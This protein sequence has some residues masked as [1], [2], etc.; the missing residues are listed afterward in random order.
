MEKVEHGWAPKPRKERRSVFPLVGPGWAAL[1]LNCVER[2]GALE[3][4]AFSGMF[5]SLKS[6]N[7]QIGKIEIP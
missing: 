5:T 7:K 4:S 3:T 6:E 1:R 2:G